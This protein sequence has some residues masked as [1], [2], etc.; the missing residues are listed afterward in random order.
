MLR[1]PQQVS[2][3][4]SN[5]LKVT[6]CLIIKAKTHISGII[7]D[8]H[9]AFFDYGQD[10]CCLHRIMIPAIIHY[11]IRGILLVLKVLPRLESVEKI[12]IWPNKAATNTGT[13]CRKLNDKR[14]YV[15]R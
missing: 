2:D 15:V 14:C 8:M 9:I 7:F 5:M 13:Y 3:P 1:L 6:V 11:S 12:I 4:M 10:H